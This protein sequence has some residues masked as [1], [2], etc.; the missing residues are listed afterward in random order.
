MIYTSYDQL[1]QRA[2]AKMVKSR[3]AVVSAADEHTI[4]AVIKAWKNGICDP[5]LIG[6][7]AKIRSL[8]SKEGED[9]A[10]FEIINE[11]DDTAAAQKAIDLVHAGEAQS[12]MKGLI[13]T[14][15]FMRAIVKRENDLRLGSTICMMGIREVPRYHK[16]LAFADCGI[17]MYPTLE[18]K[19]EIIQSCAD[20]LVKLGFDTPKVGC[21]GSVEVVN[22][23]MQDTVDSAELKRMNQA[24]EITNCIVEGPIS[25]DLAVNKEAGEIKGY[26]SPV[27]GDADLL[28]FPDLTSANIC[29]KA[30]SHT[31]GKPAAVL[32]VGTKVPVIACSRASSLETKYLCIAVA[33]ARG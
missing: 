3:I 28:I 13:Q 23:K 5:I 10:K 33:A 8:L 1:I 6:E 16:L 2:Q 25:Y 26:E 19:K 32:I 18:Q 27:C 9:P 21:L 31:S 14:A 4:G 17:C 15:D 20:T 7:E 29:T 30:L 11:T 22:P 24:G 12:I